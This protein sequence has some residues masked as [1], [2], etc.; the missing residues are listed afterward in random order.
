MAGKIKPRACAR[1]SQHTQREWSTENVLFFQGGGRY[2]DNLHAL[3][4]KQH[5][6][7]NEH[8]IVFSVVSLTQTSTLIP[9]VHHSETKFYKHFC[10]WVSPK[11]RPF[12][13]LISSKLNKIKTIGER[14][15]NFFFTRCV[16]IL[17]ISSFYVRWSL[18]RPQRDSFVSLSPFPN[19]DNSYVFVA[20]FKSAVWN[21]CRDHGGQT[22]GWPLVLLRV[23]Q[24]LPSS[25][26]SF[27]SQLVCS[28]L[29]KLSPQSIPNAS[30]VVKSL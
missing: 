7:T 3:S 11:N 16:R 9:K 4:G 1:N 22:K 15:R 21:I 17:R 20:R 27:M 13:Q 10:G 18:A 28:P 30:A 12:G 23:C 19:F 2:G 26:L 25:I 8:S 24:F 14:R 29:G 5:E 6:K